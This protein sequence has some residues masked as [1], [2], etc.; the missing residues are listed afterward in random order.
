ME[1]NLDE[2][3][4]LVRGKIFKHT[5][6]ILG[7]LLLLEGLTETFFGVTFF[8][9]E[10]SN[11]VIVMAGIMFMGSEMVLRD[12]FPGSEKSRLAL[13]SLIGLTGIAAIIVG[14]VEF[15]AE[16]MTFVAESS[17]SEDAAWLFE[18]V[19]LLSTSVIFFVKYLRNKN[20]KEED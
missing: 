17:L 4:H 8:E 6:F 2:R 19:M 12:A 7:G 1:K 16:G 3:Q 10:W 14:I 18:C 13:F 15:A 5:V 9:G 11:L 20:K